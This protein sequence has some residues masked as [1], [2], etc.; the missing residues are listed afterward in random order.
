MA[1]CR[2][3]D[4]AVDVLILHEFVEGVKVAYVHLDKLVVWLVLD[5]FEVGEVARI[6]EFVE[7]DDVVFRVLVYEEAHYVASYEAC[8]TCD[9]NI[10]FC[11]HS[12]CEFFSVDM[13]L[14]NFVAQR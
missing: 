11:S 1:F 2:K 12:E 9:D 3:V 14:V 6:S 10:S 5:V 8:A 7:V 4:D 13:L